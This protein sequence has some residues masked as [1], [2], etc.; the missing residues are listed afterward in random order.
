MVTTTEEVDISRGSMIVAGEHPL[1][2]KRA[3]AEF[4]WMAEAPIVAGK[5]IYLSAA[6]WL[7]PVV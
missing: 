3:E 5:N 6:L 4:I 2:S 7:R 1:L